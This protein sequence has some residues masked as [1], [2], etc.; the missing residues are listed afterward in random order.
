LAGALVVDVVVVVVVGAPVVGDPDLELDECEL[1][2]PQAETPATTTRLKLIPM[3]DV[4]ARRPKMPTAYPLSLSRARRGADGRYTST[5][6]KRIPWMPSSRPE[7][8]LRFGSTAATA[9]SRA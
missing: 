1:D 3:T 2:E 8:L 6:G 7:A 4:R 9:P 5:S